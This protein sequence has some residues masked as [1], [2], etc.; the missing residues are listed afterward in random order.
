MPHDLCYQDLEALAARS[1]KVPIEDIVSKSIQKVS[2]KKDSL[3]IE[4]KP[5]ELLDLLQG[6]HPHK[7]S[8]YT[9]P[10]YVS[11]IMIPFQVDRAWKGAIV[12]RPPATDTPEDIFSLPIHK[13]RNLVQGIVW[14]D[15][16][17]NGMTIQGIAKRE[18]VTSGFVG[19]LIRNSLEIG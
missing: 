13:L 3:I 6:E 14:R 12:I 5:A 7:I 1:E 9:L 17:F 18:G 4:V 15:Q 19:R 11:K 2:V 16:H 10:E 8:N